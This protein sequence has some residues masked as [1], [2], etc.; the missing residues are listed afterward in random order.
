MPRKPETYGLCCSI[1]RCR[2]QFDISTTSRSVMQKSEFL[3]HYAGRTG[4]VIGL[5]HEGQAHYA[6]P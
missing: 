4:W 5:D 1:H 2:E 6:C 3:H